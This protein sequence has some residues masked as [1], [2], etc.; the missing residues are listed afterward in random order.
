MI[1]NL[2]CFLSISLP[3]QAGWLVTPDGARITY[4][5]KQSEGYASFDQALQE[6]SDSGRIQKLDGI[7]AHWL[8]PDD[9][10]QK[11]IFTTLERDAPRE[12]TEALKSAGNM[13]NP[14]MHQLWKSFEK[15]L[16][17][18][19]TIT[20]LNASLAPHG[21]TVSRA[22]VEKFELGKGETETGHRFHGTLFLGVTKSPDRMK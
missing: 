15:A 18:T 7:F 20:K 17:A 11:E 19:P 10:F 1:F 4:S 5:A 13:H 14:K 6:L 21:L 9:T 8:L 2:L 12:L 16:L 22:S 3:V